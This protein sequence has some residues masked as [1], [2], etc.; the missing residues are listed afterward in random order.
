MLNA[1][2]RGYETI[3]IA[4]F[5]R[6]LSARIDEVRLDLAVVEQV[7]GQPDFVVHARSRRYCSSTSRPS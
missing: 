2:R 4:R 6:R 7:G 3:S 1:P 5:D